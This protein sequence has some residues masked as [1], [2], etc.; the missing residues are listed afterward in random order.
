MPPSTKIFFFLLPAFVADAPGVATAG[1]A[2][3]AGA[4]TRAAAAAAGAGAVD[5]IGS[6]C[7]PMVREAAEHVA[8]GAQML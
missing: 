5:T 3:M 7:A 4:V 2:I 1:A 8:P 6:D